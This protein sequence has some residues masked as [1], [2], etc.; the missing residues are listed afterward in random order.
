MKT[1][2]RDRLKERGLRV[3]PQRVAVLAAL[4][5]HKNHP[6]ADALVRIV[7][8]QHPSIARGTIYHILDNLVQKGLVH[9]VL[10]EENKV[11]YDAVTEPHIHLYSKEHKR[12]EDYFDDELFHLIEDYLATKEIKGF[13]VNDVRIKFLGEFTNE[14]T[15]Q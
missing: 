9:K 13:R 14:R 3:T 6:D 12:I 4:T 8:E 7:R 15:K 10:T 2:I 5:E 1:E 11:R